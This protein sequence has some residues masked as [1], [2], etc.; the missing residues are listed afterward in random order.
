MDKLEELKRDT[1]ILNL[2]SYEDYK[3]SSQELK[4]EKIRLLNEYYK[5]KY[6]DLQKLPIYIDIDGVTLDTMNL[7]KKLLYIQCGIDYDKKDRE[8]V[9]EQE[10]IANFF[11]LLD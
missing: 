1:A 10:I 8:N 2:F 7:A 6:G 5:L 3:N 9:E 4:L 11:K